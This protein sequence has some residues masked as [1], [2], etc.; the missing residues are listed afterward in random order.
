AKRRGGLPLVLGVGAAMALL[1]ASYGGAI[2]TE[3]WNPYLPVSWWVVFLLAVWSVACD[4]LPMLPVAVF[5]GSFCMQTALPYLGVGG[6]VVVV[7]FGVR[8][9]NG[10]RRRPDRAQVRD[11]LGWCAIGGGVGLLLWL[12]SIVEQFTPSPGN[13]TLIERDLRHPQDPTAGLHH[14]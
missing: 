14:G 13:L 9:F 11:T 3:A 6:A 4:D 2:L 7:L 12:P 5:A 1:Y 10:F 8:G